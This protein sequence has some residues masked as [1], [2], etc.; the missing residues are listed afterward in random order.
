MNLNKE[1]RKIIRGLIVFTM[2]VFIVGINYRTVLD[3][4][5]TIFGILFPFVLGGGIAFVLNVPMRS[6]ERIL[7]VKK[8][9]KLKRPISLVLT[10][11]LVSGVLFLVGFLVIPE[12]VRTIASV[13]ESV[14]VFWENAQAEAEAFFVN[15]PYIV[16]YIEEMDVNWKQL[17]GEIMAF[18]GNGA[19]TVL[20]STVSA[21]MSVINGLTT[22]FIGFVFA[23]Y[24]LLQKETLGRQV[25][26]ALR[27][28]LPERT[29]AVILEIAALTERTFS[30]F[31]TGQCLEAVILGLMF[32][33]TLTVMRY[34]YAVLIGVLIAFTALIP[35]FGAFIGCFVGAF[36]IL[37]VNPMQALVFVIVFLILQQIEGNLIYPHVVGNSV[38]LP[39]IWVL[40]A[41]TIG[42]SVMGITGMLIFIPLCSVFYSLLRDAANA[43]LALTGQK[44]EEEIQDE[45]T[46]SEEA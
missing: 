10:L 46:K 39:S 15:Y 1:N 32:F 41:V 35:I 16:G 22:F 20:S 4:A 18:L 28:F 13:S 37:M 24:I 34:P 44:K 31:L 36:L 29:G 45:D 8:H 6:V 2:V 9:E 27:A 17:I 7:P 19:G 12:L 33:A 23:I 26:K 43:R 40:A 5:G 42:G 3:L 11:A 21:A 25:R 30:N 38:G 14:P